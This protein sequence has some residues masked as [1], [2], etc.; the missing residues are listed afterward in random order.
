MAVIEY[1]YSNIIQVDYD[2]IFTRPGQSKGLLYKHC[3]H[4]LNY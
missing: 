1:M 3:I 2:M 4:A